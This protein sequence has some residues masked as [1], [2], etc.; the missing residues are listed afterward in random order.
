[1]SHIL[2]PTDFSIPSHNAYRYGLHLAKELDLD[3]VLVHYYSGSIDPRTSLYIGGDGSIQGSFEERLRQFAYP[4]G[5][6]SRYPLVEPP[7]GVNLSFETDVSL[8]PAT[9]II[10][11]AARADITMVV[12][13]PRSGKAILG[14]WL[15]STATTVS[16]ACDKPVFIVPPHMRYRPFRRLVVANNHATADPYPLWQLSE[17]AEHFGSKVDFVHVQHAGEDRRFVPWQLMEQLVE[18]DDGAHFPFEVSTVQ[19]RDLSQ[20]LLD[21]ADN[22]SADLIV[23]VNRTRTRWRAFLQATLTQDLALRSRIP[24]LVLHTANDERNTTA[25]ESYRE[26]EEV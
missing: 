2:I 10:R 1:M 13:A 22:I 11:R 4:S 23:I 24:V 20:G 17:L 8:T 7:S 12:M 3:V 16:E 26:S 6:G 14:K 15:G 21:Y 18:S 9:A 5:D 19:G 25:F